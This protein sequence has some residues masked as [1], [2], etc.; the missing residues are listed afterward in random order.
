MTKWAHGRL[1]LSDL[2]W[3]LQTEFDDEP[4]KN[5]GWFK[6]V[7]FPVWTDRLR[8]AIEKTPGGD[9]NLWL[10]VKKEA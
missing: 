3:E 10:F 8:V 4:L 6:P 7:V 9:F 1:R 5:W 2:S